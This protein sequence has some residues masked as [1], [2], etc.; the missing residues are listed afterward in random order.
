MYQYFARRY[1]LNIQAVLW[2][3]DV[4]PDQEQWR[5]LQ[6][7]LNQHKA[8]WMIWEGEPVADT[9]SRLQATGINS[10]VFDPSANKPNQG[11]FLSVMRSNLNNLQSVFQ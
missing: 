4:V 3:P 9:A 10:T 11:D 8:K 1:R 5:Q 6:S 7:M 2:E